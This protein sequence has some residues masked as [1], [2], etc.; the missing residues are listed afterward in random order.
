MCLSRAHQ[1]E[2]W[3]VA[4]WSCPWRHS[5]EQLAAV[6]D[7]PQLVHILPS[8]TV[9]ITLTCPECGAVRTQQRHNVRKRVGDD[10]PAI[11]WKNGTGFDRC[12][13]C[14]SIDNLTAYHDKN[15]KRYGTKFYV[16]QGK[17]LYASLTSEQI[18]KTLEAAHAKNRD[19]VWTEA[20]RRNLSKGHITS[21]PKGN[22]GICRLCRLIVYVSERNTRAECHA[23]C[24]AAWRSKTKS[25]GYPPLDPKAASPLPITWPSLSPCVFG[26]CCEARR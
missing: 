15:K 5:L 18:A 16:E 17:R 21:T 12:H 25:F 22:F 4:S 19:H 23:F 20:E 2:C 6:V 1:R 24:L 3:Q 14:A 7:A 8:K 13:R 10:D 26:A 11:N 9:R